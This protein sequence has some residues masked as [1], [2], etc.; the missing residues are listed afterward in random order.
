YDDE[1]E[2]DT[3]GDDE[4]LPE[5]PRYSASEDEYVDMLDT[6]EEETPP[7]EVDDEEV[8]FGDDDDDDDFA[9]ED[10]PTYVDED[11]EPVEAVSDRR[12]KIEQGL[13]QAA[14]EAREKAQAA[15]R[16]RSAARQSD[17]S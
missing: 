13:A 17:K 12:S 16:E 14:A 3:F 11:A 9:A 2:A 6:S 1:P 5:T 10:D 15:A 7:W 4:E 8:S